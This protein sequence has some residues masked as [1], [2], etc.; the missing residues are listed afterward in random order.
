[1]KKMLFTSPTCKYCV[2]AKEMLSDDKDVEIINVME[3]EAL[4]VKYGI[5][6]VPT[7]V[8]DKCSGPEIYVGLDKITSFVNKKVEENGSCG[9]SCGE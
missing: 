6:S 8:V 5:R 9:C 2:P 7:L 1:M 4:A 3:N